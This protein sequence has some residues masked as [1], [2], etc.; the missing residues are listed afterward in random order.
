MPCR[1]STSFLAGLARE[2]HA[3]LPLLIAADRDL[4]GDGQA[5]AKQAAEAS[6]AAVALP[7]V[8]GD[9]NDAFM[10]LGEDSARRALAESRHAARRQSVRRDER[11]GIFGHECQ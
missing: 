3:A 8:F 9:W 11:G 1:P 2:K 10:Q 7:P 6:R 5:K 4:N